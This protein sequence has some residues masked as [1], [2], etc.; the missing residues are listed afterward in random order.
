M[1]PDEFGQLLGQ[2]GA[3]GNI[4]GNFAT[5]TIQEAAD[6]VAYMIAPLG[7]HPSP[8]PADASYWAELRATDWAF[9]SL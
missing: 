5:G 3:I 7:R 2:S 8:D 1:G 4:V 9:R 6:F